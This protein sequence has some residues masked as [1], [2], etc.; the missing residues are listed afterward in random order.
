MSQ[1]AYVLELRGLVATER[2][3]GHHLVDGT[4]LSQDDQCEFGPKHMPSE[5]G[6]D[7]ARGRSSRMR[8]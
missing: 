1:K 6:H 4:K 8:A 7:I 2:A 5:R 3:L